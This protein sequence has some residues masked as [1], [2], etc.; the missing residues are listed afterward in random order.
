[1]IQVN[2]DER[3]KTGE[4]FHPLRGPAGL[5]RE[6]GTGPPYG[7]RGPETIPKLDLGFFAEI[8]RLAKTQHLTHVLQQSLQDH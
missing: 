3:I 5:K 8:R 2:P 6:N 1:M 4:I 7:N